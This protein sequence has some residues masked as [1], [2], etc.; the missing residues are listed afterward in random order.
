VGDQVFDALGDDDLGRAAAQ[1]AGGSDDA[2]E[3]WD[4]EVVHVGVGDEDG[5]DGGKV[6]DEEAGLALAAEDDEAGG[7]D[8]V[9]EDVAAA[10]LEEEGGVADEGDAELGGGDQFGG[11]GLA[12]ERALMA[13]TG[14]AQKLAHL[15][16]RERPS[17]PEPAHRTFAGSHTIVDADRVGADEGGED[18]FG[19]LTYL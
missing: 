18:G 17:F 11:A 10:D 12:G 5:V 16:D 19:I 13:L 14:D 8:G 6:F 15:S 9:D 4:V 3:R 2:A 1:A 7:E